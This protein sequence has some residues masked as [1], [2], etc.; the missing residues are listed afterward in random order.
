MNTCLSR[1]EYDLLALPSTARLSKTR[2]S[3]P[4]LGDDVFEGSLNGPVLAEAGFSD[5][6]EAL[7]FVPTARRGAGPCAARVVRGR[8]HGRRA[9][10]RRHTRQRFTAGAVGLVG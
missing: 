10:Q 2:F 8:G 1:V 6:G 5:G 3:V 9:L 4:P 7:V